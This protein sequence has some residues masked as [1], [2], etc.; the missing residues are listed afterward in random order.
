MPV[1]PFRALDRQPRSIVV[2]LTT[3][4]ESFVRRPST[5]PTRAVEACWIVTVEQARKYCITNRGGNGIPS[6][7]DLLVKDLVSY[8]TFCTRNT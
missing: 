2:T 8:R 4:T 1:E 7:E 6:C 3:D 5:A